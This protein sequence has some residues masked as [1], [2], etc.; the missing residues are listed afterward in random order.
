[1]RT[2][3]STLFVSDGA[4]L[5]I[6]ETSDR[7]HPKMI[8]RVSAPQTGV[9]VTFPFG[10][11]WLQTVGGQFQTVDVDP[12]SEAHFVGSPIAPLPGY[13]SSLSR[14]SRDL[15]YWFMA[16]VHPDCR[17]SITYD[18]ADPSS[19]SVVSSATMNSDDNHTT[20]MDDRFLYTTSQEG[21]WIYKL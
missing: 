21:V 14:T 12:P 2:S 7:A 1:M 17:K 4:A 10:Y 11:V 16:D 6:Y 3:G 13:G 20:E 5:S 9:A 19:P 15:R 18:L 8:S